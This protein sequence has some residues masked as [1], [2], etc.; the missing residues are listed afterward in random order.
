MTGLS[1][2]QQAFLDLLGDA[3]Q[4]TTVVRELA[5]FLDARGPVTAEDVLSGPLTHRAIIDAFVIRFARLQ[6]LLGSKLL[7]A[8]AAIETGDRRPS[9]DTALT[10]AVSVGIVSDQ[11]LWL[12]LRYLRNHFVHEYERDLPVLVAAIN[13]ALAHAAALERTVDQ[14]ETYARRWA[15]P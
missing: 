13:E 6:D 9:I 5:D 3:R 2:E 10:V 14:A 7:R 11:P 1:P 4:A 15:P 8:A 12:R